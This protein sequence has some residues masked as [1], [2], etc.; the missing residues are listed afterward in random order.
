MFSTDL[1]KVGTSIKLQL[2]VITCINSGIV[3]GLFSNTLFFELNFYVLPT[4]VYSS[5]PSRFFFYFR[6]HA[7]FTTGATVTGLLE[8]LDSLMGCDLGNICAK[9]EQ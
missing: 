8:V 7:I 3:P 9:A 2:S 1:R 6:S 5:W 4:E